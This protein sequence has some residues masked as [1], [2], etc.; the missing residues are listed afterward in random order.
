M[1]VLFVYYLP[2]GG[3]ETLNRQRSIALKRKNI[4]CHFLYYRKER[5]LINDHHAP[6]FITNNLNFRTLKID[7]VLSLSKP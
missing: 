3:V 4:N 2:S 6:T 5:E 7:L 1:N